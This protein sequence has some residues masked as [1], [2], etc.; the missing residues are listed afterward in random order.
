[1]SPPKD[2]QRS[3]MSLPKA[4]TDEPRRHIQKFKILTF[5]MRKLT[6]VNSGKGA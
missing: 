5:L 2:T 1:M 6:K 3:R 4:H